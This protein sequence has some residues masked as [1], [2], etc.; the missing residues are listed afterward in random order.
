MAR[1]TRSHK[2]NAEDSSH[3]LPKVDDKVEDEE[4]PNTVAGRRR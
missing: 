2:N 4:T 1:P 3:P